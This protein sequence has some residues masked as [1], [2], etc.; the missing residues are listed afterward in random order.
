MFQIDDETPKT[1]HYKKEL[2]DKDLDTIKSH[3]EKY[4]KDDTPEKK[5]GQDKQEKQHT[6]RRDEKR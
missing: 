1:F 5:K 4:N 3:I 6:Q 2:W